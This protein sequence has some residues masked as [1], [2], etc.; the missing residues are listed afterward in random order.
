MKTL[1]TLA[2]FLS[3]HLA[4]AQTNVYQPY[5]LDN[6]SW[7]IRTVN[8]N[9]GPPAIEEWHTKNWS[10]EVIIN[11]VTYIEVFDDP[12]M[13]G[14]RQDI[15]NEQIF[16]VDNQGVEYDASFD[17]DV[18]VGDTVILTEAFLI[19]NMFPE[20]TNGS[21]I[22]GDAIIQGIDSVLVGPTYRKRISMISDV[23]T[24]GFFDASYICGVHFSSAT[25]SISNAMSLACFYVEGQ[26]YLGDP[27]NPNC[28]AGIE[29]LLEV[30][31]QIYPNPSNEVFFIDFDES[32]TLLEVNL[33]D[34]T[35]KRIT[36]FDKNKTKSGFDISNLPSGTYLVEAIFEK[37][38]SQ[39]VLLKE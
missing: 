4:Q 17:Q 21:G 16:Y 28:T 25:T 14:V 12:N 30:S 38:K 23:N 35:G 1:A 10:G 31:M 29:E 7:T 22:G 34:L 20:G 32:E 8:G 39:S 9:S 18:Q 3:I 15:P 11:G 36:S 37:G 2:L 5:P 33:L 19:L 27:F 24:T 6:A 13:V 26:Q